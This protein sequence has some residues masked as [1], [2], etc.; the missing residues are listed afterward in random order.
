M[1]RANSLCI[2]LDK[3]SV[4]APTA[5]THTA[6]AQPPIQRCVST[7]AVH[8]ANP[9]VSEHLVIRLKRAPASLPGNHLFEESRALIPPKA[10]KLSPL[11]QCFTEPAPFELPPPLSLVLGFEPTPPAKIRK[12]RPRDAE[13]SPEPI[14]LPP[15][16]RQSAEPP[17]FGTS[18]LQ[19][20][21]GT[22]MF[23]QHVPLERVSSIF[24]IC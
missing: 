2:H 7:S 4:D 24:D 6:H 12:L 11:R 22:S 16:M 23:E 19:P 18:M 14:R 13:A 5:T 15:A 3:L 1:R 9:P 17:R 20:A 21:L 8:S 10:P